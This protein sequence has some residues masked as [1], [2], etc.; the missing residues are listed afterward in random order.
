MNYDELFHYKDYRSGMLTNGIERSA[1]R[2]LLYSTGLEERDLHKPLVAIVNSFTEMVP[3][4][5]HLRQLAQDV[6]KGVWE[7]GEDATFAKQKADFAAYCKSHEASTAKRMEGHEPE[8]IEDAY[9]N[10]YE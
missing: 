9:E 3:G 5:E 8:F 1:H 2:A 4:H 7:A 6:A 10:I